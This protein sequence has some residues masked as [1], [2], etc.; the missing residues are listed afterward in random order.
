MQPTTLTGANAYVTGAGASLTTTWAQFSGV[1]TAPANTASMKVALINYLSSGWVAFDDISVTL[2]GAEANLVTNPGF[3][4]VGNWTTNPT[5]PGTW[6][7]RS[8][9]GEAAPHSGSYGYAISNNAYGSLT[10]GSVAVSEKTEYKLA[11]WLR[12]ELDDA[13]GIGGWIVRANFYNAPGELLSTAD[14]VSGRGSSLSTTWQ[15]VTGTVTAPEGASAMKIVLINQ[16]SSGWVAFE[17]V[18]A[19]QLKPATKYYYAGDQ[20]VGLRTNGALT[21]LL[22]DHLGSTSLAL[23]AGGAKTAE[24]R[25]RAWGEVR[26]G[27]S[28]GEGLPSNYTYTGQ[29]SYMDDP[30]TPAAEGF[31]LMYYNARWLDPALGRFS[32]ADTIVPGGMQG[33][34]RYAYTFNNPLKYT[35]PSGHEICDADGNWRSVA[36]QLIRNGHCCPCTY[37]PGR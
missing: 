1:V 10:S 33:L 26:Y 23:D 3:E 18:S 5:S 8:T 29:R 25:Y 17:D 37:V 4:S 14:A 31:G 12:G 32:Q 15:Q 27:W 28:A 24:L 11:T 35:D 2:N 9:W 34:D 19:T 30:T 16:Q 22:G 20:R 7:W 13:E 6:L 36:R 21:Y